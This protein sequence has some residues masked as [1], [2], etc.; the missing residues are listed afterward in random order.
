MTHAFEFRLCEYQRERMHLLHGLFEA[1]GND[2]DV[3]I[4]GTAEV[5]GSGISSRCSPWPLW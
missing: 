5:G 3:D 1:E 4:H 2:L